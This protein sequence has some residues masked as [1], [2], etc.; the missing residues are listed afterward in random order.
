M[1]NHHKK[2]VFT[3]FLFVVCGLWIIELLLKMAKWLILSVKQPSLSQIPSTYG[4]E[5]AAKKEHVLNRIARF[6]AIFSAILSI[7]MLIASLAFDPNAMLPGLF[8]GV[9]ALILYILNRI[10]LT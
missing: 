8:F 2:N 4:A 5:K 7:S 1:S 3:V 6:V 10:R 9:I